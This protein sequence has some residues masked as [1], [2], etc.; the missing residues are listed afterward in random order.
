MVTHLSHLGVAFITLP[1]FHA[2]PHLNFLSSFLLL[3]LDGGEMEI[4]VAQQLKV[5]CIFISLSAI[6]VMRVQILR[7]FF[8]VLKKR[9][10]I[11]FTLNTLTVEV[12]GC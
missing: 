2:L 1:F 11:Q 10:E 3:Q 12:E 4:L 6:T 8:I 7:A 5:M 9:T